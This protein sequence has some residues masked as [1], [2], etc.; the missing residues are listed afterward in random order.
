MTRTSASE[1][2][3][4]VRD[5]SRQLIA[6]LREERRATK[7]SP[8]AAIAK[9]ASVRPSPPSVSR[10]VAPPPPVARAPAPKPA[11]P[12]GKAQKRPSVVEAAA[13]APPA[14]N[15]AAKKP[16]SDRPAAAPQPQ[17][18][19]A[20]VDIEAISGLGSALKTKLRRLGLGTADKLAMQSPDGLRAQL[21]PVARLVNLESL[22]RSASAASGSLD[23][24]PR[25][26]AR[27]ANGAA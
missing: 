5:R 9:P 21:G 14:T 8:A 12:P 11:A 17:A 15:R 10:L 20:P 4:E 27:S 13:S 24:A 7:R 19:R 1:R 22:I 23:P 18:P 26:P 2:L 25:R 3:K 16:A 6:S